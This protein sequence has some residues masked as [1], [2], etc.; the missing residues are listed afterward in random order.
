MR[1]QGADRSVCQNSVCQNSVCQN[2][3]SVIIFLR[4]VQRFNNVRRKGCFLSEPG[5]NCEVYA[6]P[7]AV[8][9]RRSER[10][11]WFQLSVD[12]SV[13]HVKALTSPCERR[14]PACAGSPRSAAGAARCKSPHIRPPLLEFPPR[15]R[16]I[17][18]DSVVA[19]EQVDLDVAAFVAGSQ[20]RSYP[21]F[22]DLVRPSLHFLMA[23]FSVVYDLHLNEI[24][25]PPPCPAEPDLR[26]TGRPG[27]RGS[28]R[29]AGPASA[30]CPCP[31]RGRR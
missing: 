5:V 27:C 23:F 4:Q 13:L 11:A 2:Q 6:L 22:A 3:D 17:V 10:Y 28:R 25:P 14:G 7:P 26:V 8:D 9:V 24:I 29:C 15:F 31:M 30:A 18:A 16:R 21:G 20:A 19:A 1:R 12:S